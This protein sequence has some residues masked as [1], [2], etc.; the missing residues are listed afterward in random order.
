[1]PE[2]TFLLSTCLFEQRCTIGSLFEYIYDPIR[3]VEDI[4]GRVTVAGLARTC[5]TYK[6]PAL[7]V[8]WTQLNSLDLSRSVLVGAKITGT[9]Q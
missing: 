4:E 9:N 8:L 5:R 6:D 1:V 2:H 7:D 3:E